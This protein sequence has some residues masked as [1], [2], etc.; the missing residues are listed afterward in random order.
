MPTTREPLRI[1]LTLDDGL[2]SYLRALCKSDMAIFG[3]E[4]ETII[5]A[6][7][8]FLLSKMTK[9]NAFRESIIDNLPDDLQAH[10]RATPG[11]D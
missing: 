1:R 6:V 10:W 4:R 2:A 5:F 9:G 7:R 11:K 8:E 3:N